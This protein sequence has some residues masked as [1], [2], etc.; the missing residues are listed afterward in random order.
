MGGARD[1]T[2]ASKKRGV[3]GPRLGLIVED[4]DAAAATPEDD[5]SAVVAAAVDRARMPVPEARGGGKDE[6]GF[7]ITDHT[8]RVGELRLTN[9]G[10]LSYRGES[11]A[12]AAA[13]A[14][15]S[16]AA[17]GF[18]DFADLEMIKRL[19]AGASST[20]RLAR[21]RRTGR[22]VALKCIAVR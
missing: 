10:D 9:D 12:A 17:S 14:A 3:K 8:L 5:S 7:S 15:S 18:V 13:A 16:A 2:A 6:G 21:E 20:V 4:S 11:A 19:G 1:A 22:L